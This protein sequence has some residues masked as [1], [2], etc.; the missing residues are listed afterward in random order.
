MQGERW[1]NMALSKEEKALIGRRIKEIRLE[2]GMTTKE[3]G[4]LFGATDSNV[5]SWEKGRTSPA[6]ERLKA[7]AKIGDTTVEALLSNSKKEYAL[8]Y[9]LK[10]LKEILYKEPHIDID[11]ENSEFV[12]KYGGDILQVIKKQIDFLNLS[13]YSN[14]DI[15][16]FVDD[17]IANSVYSTPKNTRSLLGDIKLTLSN[18]V[19][20]ISEYSGEI[21]NFSSNL[22]ISDNLDSKITT[23]AKN[24]LNNA[25]K[26]I[27]T[28]I[29]NCD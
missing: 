18:E 6:P 25:I 11:V 24:I 23:E 5:T 12:Y 7:I 19:K 2:K 22:N 3:F 21:N 27:E 17:I 29:N 28:L 15:E 20:K 4:K 16:N 9:A 10:S 13:I 8:E 14:T 26:E 1:D